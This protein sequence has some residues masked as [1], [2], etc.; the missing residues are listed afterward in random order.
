MII[1]IGTDLIEVKRIKKAC[2][3]KA[4]LVRCFTEKERFFI[5]EDPHKAADNFAVKEAVSKVM[6]TG[7]AG[8][9]PS[10]IEVLRHDNGRPYINLYGKA[11]DKAKKLGIRTFHISITNT[12][13]HSM[14]FVIGED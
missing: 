11:H 6:G 13:D 4:F 9:H 1:G 10:E 2:E 14:A 3:R 8:F 12:V 7:F 5:N